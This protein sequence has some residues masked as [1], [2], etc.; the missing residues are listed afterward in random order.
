M[1]VLAAD[2]DPTCTLPNA[3]DP[4]TSVGFASVPVPSSVTD[5]GLFAASS[6]NVKFPVSAPF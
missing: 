3:I 4:G 2:T 1:M 5:W 6:E